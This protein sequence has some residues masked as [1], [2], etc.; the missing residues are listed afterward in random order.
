MIDNWQ[1]KLISEWSGRITI[2]EN[3]VV[4]KGLADQA[5]VIPSSMFPLKDKKYSIFCEYNTEDFVDG[6]ELKEKAFKAFDRVESKVG[7]CY[8][9]SKLLLEELRKEGIQAE[10]Y[11]GWIF[12]GANLLPLHHCFIVVEGNK[13]LD[14]GVLFNEKDYADLNTKRFALTPEETRKLTLEK[15]KE[16]LSLPNHERFCIGKVYSKYYYVA[17][18]CDCDEGLEIYNKLLKTYPNHISFI[19]P[20]GAGNETEMQKMIK[21]LGNY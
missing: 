11:V 10:S 13:V 3:R 1:E 21:S 7:K 8:K 4:F 16:K 2:K 14:Y 12:I 17:S 6:S 20:R 5:V 18:P 19:K 15:F 9:N